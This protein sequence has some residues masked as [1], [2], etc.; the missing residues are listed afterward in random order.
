MSEHQVI[1]TSTIYSFPRAIRHGMFGPA[2]DAADT[3]RDRDTVMLLRRTYRLLRKAGLL[4]FEAR[5]DLWVLL[6]APVEELQVERV[7]L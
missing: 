6:T 4:D 5:H 3:I 1:T 7:T 2:V